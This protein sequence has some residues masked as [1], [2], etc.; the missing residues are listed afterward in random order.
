MPCMGGL[1]GGGGTTV[2]TVDS[3]CPAGDVCLGG[4]GG[5]TGLPVSVCVRGRVPFD[6]GGFRQRDGG[7]FRRPP[8]DAGGD[9][10]G[11]SSAANN[12]M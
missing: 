11:D 7:G 8:R 4:G 6:A 10:N 5:G 3:D 12:D 1:G 9:G 2:C